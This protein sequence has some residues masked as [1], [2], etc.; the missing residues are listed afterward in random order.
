MHFLRN[1]TIEADRVTGSGA[2]TNSFKNNR[3]LISKREA[4]ALILRNGGSPEARK[5]KV[6]RVDLFTDGTYG[7]TAVL[8]T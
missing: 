8:K 7:P 6:S 4:Y 5:V 2:K 1:G 3:G